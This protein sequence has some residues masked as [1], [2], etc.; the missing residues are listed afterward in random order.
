[1][2]PETIARLEHAFT[3]GCTDLEAAFYAGIN[4]DTM[5]KYQNRH[6]EFVARK[7]ALKQSMVYQAR[8]TIRKNLTCDDKKERGI[9]ARWLLEKKAPEEFGS[10]AE[11]TV[12]HSGSLSLNDRENALNE[13]LK[14]FE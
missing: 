4:V 9:T 7:N 1:M 10:K 14:R 5:Y 12:N 2:T 13:F 6:P 3:L 8:E 11:L